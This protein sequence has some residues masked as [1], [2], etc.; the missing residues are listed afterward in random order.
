[1]VIHQVFQVLK[2]LFLH[3]RAAVTKKTIHL[4]YSFAFGEKGSGNWS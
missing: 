2:R 3:P 1:M 4:L